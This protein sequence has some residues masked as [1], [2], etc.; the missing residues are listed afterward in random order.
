MTH[1]WPQGGLESECRSFFLNA[2]CRQR[3]SSRDH[4]RRL[5]VIDQIPIQTSEKS[6]NPWSG[7]WAKSI[8]VSAMP[9]LTLTVVY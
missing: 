5:F 9:A 3:E 8:Y 4:G 2:G 7:L 1:G 6:T